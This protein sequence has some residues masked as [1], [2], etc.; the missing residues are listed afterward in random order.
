MA[1]PGR[2][3]IRGDIHAEPASRPPM[4]DVVCDLWQPES[5]PGGY[6]SLGVAE[7]TLMHQEMIEYMKKTFNI[8][9]HFLTYG[10]GFTGSHLL[11]EVAAKFINERFRPVNPVLKKHISITSGVGP[12]LELSSFS[13]CDPGDGILLGRPYY[14]TFPSDMGARAGA[15]IVAVSFGGIDPLSQEAIAFYEQALLDAKERGITT[16]ALILCNPHN[17]LGRCYPRSVIEGYM[18]LCQKYSLHL[19]SDEIYALSIWDNPDAAD[20][21]GFT[22]A[23]SIDTTDLIDSDLVHVLWG[24]SKDFGSNGIRLG[25]II[26]TN[27]PFQQAVEANAYWT[28]ASAL[29]DQATARIL[30]DTAFVDSYVATNQ[31][32]LAASYAVTT[33]FLRENNV[34][35][36]KGGNAGFFVWIDLFAWLKKNVEIKSSEAELWALEAELQATLLRNRVFLACG[37]AFGSDVPG[38]FRIVFA[39]EKEYLEEGLRRMLKTVQSFSQGLRNQ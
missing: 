26:S 3:S 10:D 16:K 21:P 34:P 27:E 6:L 13:L 11:R 18:R 29:T 30:A 8:E 23:L 19:L 24:M 36:E 5:N 14:G 32:R 33:R 17:P 37:K 38:R 25:C 4:L 28:C 22:S 9:S 35:Y 31:A 39:H 7:N 20:A 12:A 1:R 2:L 15:Q